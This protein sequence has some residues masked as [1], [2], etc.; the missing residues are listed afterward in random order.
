MV[1]GSKSWF[2]P[3][4]G[5][6]VT[7]WIQQLNFCMTRKM[8]QSID[9]WYMSSELNHVIGSEHYTKS[10]DEFYIVIMVYL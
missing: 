9:D 2:F 3:R 10:Y 5:L 7:L 4:G 8:A 6:D 1:Y